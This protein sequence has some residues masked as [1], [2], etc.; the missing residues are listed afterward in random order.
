MRFLLRFF[1]NPLADKPP[2][3]Y[4]PAAHTSDKRSTRHTTWGKRRGNVSSG[5]GKLVNWP[6]PDETACPGSPCCPLETLA[7]RGEARWDARDL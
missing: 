2:S 4:T 3:R 5:R 7:R 1:M 6:A